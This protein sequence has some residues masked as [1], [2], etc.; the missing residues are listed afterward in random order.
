LWCGTSKATANGEGSEFPFNMNYLTLLAVS[1]RDGAAQKVWFFAGLSAIFAAFGRFVRGVTTGGAIAGA[2]VCFALLW[3]GGTSAFA[4]LL[5]VFL[6]TWVA[7][8]VGYYR[9]E[10][11]GTAEARSGRNAMQVLANL[12]TPAACAVLYAGFSPDR[13][14]LIAMTAALAEAA[15]DTVSSEI[16]QAVGGTPWLVTTGRQ[17]KLGTNGAITVAGTAAG[18]VAAATVAGV[19][20]AFSHLGWF[21]FFLVVFA[22]VAG[23]IIDSLLGATIEGRRGFGNNAVNF[24][25]TI[26]AAIIALFIVP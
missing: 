13:R 1:L 23:T 26:L 12:G 15:G 3:S 17:V 2:L 18:A 9:K 10:R 24:I 5:T 19:F 7:T 21:T 14:L 4:A 8:R 20:I 22:G 6:L 25:S 11:L 16:G